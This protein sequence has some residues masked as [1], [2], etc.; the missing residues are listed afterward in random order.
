MFDFI[1]RFDFSVLYFIQEHICNPFL[2][3]VSV[4]LSKAFNGGIAWIVLC[5]LLLIFR[6]T[7]YM[8]IV[9]ITALALALLIGELGLKNVICRPRPCHIDP[10]ISLLV[11]TPSSYSCPSGHTGSSF[12]AA[13]ALFL[14]NKKWGIP[15]LVMAVIIG[16]SRMYL[17]VHFPTDVLFG[18]VVGIV[19]GILAYLIYKKVGLKEK[20]EKVKQ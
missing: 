15:A 5:A 1:T 19:G 9:A 8:G 12:A 11:K 7:R 20:F 18:A 2:D 10:S 13:T 4:F 17:F 3:V 16:L 6:K 14:C